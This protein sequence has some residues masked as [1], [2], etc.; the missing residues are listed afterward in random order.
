MTPW[1]LI[2]FS[3]SHIPQTVES[4]EKIQNTEVDGGPLGIYNHSTYWNILQF[5]LL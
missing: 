4:Q 3:D 2:Q 5:T 1:H